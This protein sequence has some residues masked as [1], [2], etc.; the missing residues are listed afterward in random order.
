MEDRTQRMTDKPPRRGT[1]RPNLRAITDRTKPASGKPASGIPAGGEGYGGPA[2]PGNPP[3]IGPTSA[4][5]L[6]GRARNALISDMAQARVNAAFARI[7]AVMADDMHPHAF[8]AAKYVIDRIAGTPA[9]SVTVT[10]E[11]P[12]VTTYR[13]LPEIEGSPE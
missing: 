5:V 4:Q 1:P 2:R 8:N 7:D 12:A 3:G 13:W 9:A 11:A 6:D 10:E